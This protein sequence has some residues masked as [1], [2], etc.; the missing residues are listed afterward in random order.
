MIL[1]DFSNCNMIE[2][3]RILAHFKADL[4]VLLSDF[5]NTVIVVL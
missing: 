4:R 3:A 1:S 2:N 5:S